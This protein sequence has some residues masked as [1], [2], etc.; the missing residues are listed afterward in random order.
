MQSASPDLPPVIQRLRSFKS[1]PDRHKSKGDD[2][3][4]LSKAVAQRFCDLI[5]ES[6]K[7]V[8]QI[9]AEN[10]DLPSFKRLYNWQQNVP[11]FNAMWS[12][13]RIKQTHFFAQKCVDLYNSAEPKTAHVVRIKFDILKWLCAKFNPEIFAEK[14]AAA[15]V[16]TVNVGIAI[17]PQ[18]LSEL[19]TK[20][21]HSRT[22]LKP[23]VPALEPV[24]H[25][26]KH[27]HPIRSEHTE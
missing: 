14:P 10:P 24:G 18:R 17:D 2:S 19:R 5:S 8:Q 11:W 9:L 6:D 20:L 7:S 26:P 13:A 23:A 16:Q 22:A 21:D 1:N 3:Y 15:P 4:K 12:Q 27:V 25:A